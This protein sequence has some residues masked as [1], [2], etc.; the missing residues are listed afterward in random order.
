M[1]DMKLIV[2]INFN[3]LLSGL[4]SGLKYMFMIFIFFSRG[5]MLAINFL[6]RHWDNCLVLALLIDY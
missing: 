5:M 6:N 1:V 4:N 2:N 3:H